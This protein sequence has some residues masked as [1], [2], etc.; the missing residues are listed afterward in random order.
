MKIAPIDIAH[1]S[2]G[3]KM[4]GF[5]PEEVMDFLR[6]VSTEMEGLI[7]ER[8]TLKENLREKELQINEFRERDELLKHTITTATRMSEKMQKDS[9]RES[10]LIIGDAKQ[11]ADLIVSD[12]RDSLKKDLSRNCRFKTGS[13]AI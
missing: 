9:E 13:I 12:A 4:M 5:D 2:F 6:N 1:K 8:N 3:R 7:R 10:K 11:Q